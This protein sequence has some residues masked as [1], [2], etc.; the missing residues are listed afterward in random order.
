MEILRKTARITL[1]HLSLSF[2]SWH[3]LHRAKVHKSPL[4]LI[5][6]PQIIQILV[7][8]LKALNKIMNTQPWNNKLKVI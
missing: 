5:I 1:P 3:P 4:S 8:Y 2:N 6:Y 7:G